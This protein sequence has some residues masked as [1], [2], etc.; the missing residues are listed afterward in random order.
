M[1]KQNFAYAR[2]IGQQGVF[3]RTEFRQLQMCV[4][5][6]NSASVEVRNRLADILVKN[7]QRLV[8]S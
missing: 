5:P 4:H 7:E 3:T 6:D 2:L 8:K 1:K